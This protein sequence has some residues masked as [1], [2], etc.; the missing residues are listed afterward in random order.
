MCRAVAVSTQRRLFRARWGVCQ[1]IRCRA[2]NELS[3]RRVVSNCGSEIPVIE[4]GAIPAPRAVWLGNGPSRMGG[5]G[6]HSNYAGGP[7]TGAAL[8][9]TQRVPVPILPCSTTAGCLPPMAA[10]LTGKSRLQIG[11]A[12][13]LAPAAGVEHD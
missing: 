11:Q 7:R 5:W 12:N 4:Y 13:V 9:L 10:N 3:Q 6:R 2:R 8:K 1:K